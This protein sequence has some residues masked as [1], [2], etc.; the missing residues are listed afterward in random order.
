MNILMELER[1]TLA[2]EDI[3]SIQILIF[4]NLVSNLKA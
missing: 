4:Q 3:K 1:T 2:I